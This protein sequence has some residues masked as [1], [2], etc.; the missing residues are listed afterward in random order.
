MLSFQQL[1]DYRALSTS[2]QSRPSLRTYMFTNDFFV[3]PEDVDGDEYQI[4]YYPAMNEPAPMN[5]RGAAAHILNAQGGSKRQAA[6]FYA[7]NCLP[8][9]MSGLE[10]LREPDSET[11]QD[12]A[13]KTIGQQFD[14]F[15]ERHR[16]YKELVISKIMTNGVVYANAAGQ[17]LEDSTGAV[18]TADMGV[19]A[20]HKGNLNG[21]VTALWSVAGT[22]IATQLDN[23]KNQAE[24]EGAEPPTEIYVH[25]LSKI[26]LRANTEFQTWAVENNQIADTIL[27]G[28]MIPDLWGFNW[29]FYGG[30]YKGADGNMKDFIPTTK[31]V[32]CPKPGPWLRAANG[33]TL[34]PSSLEISQ[35]VEQAL[36]NVAKVYGQYAYAKL[37]DNP[38]KLAMFMGDVFG[39]NFADPASI[40]QPTVF[41]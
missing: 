22:K 12:K 6:L 19:S 4:V 27:R 2:Y 24:A 30:K 34:V 31:A 20:N 1:L 21:L 41:G 18:I 3:S 8:F 32:I 7:F 14:Q 26:H 13:R 39:L 35:T 38:L 25:S 15:A 17:I 29:H 37:L 9:P 40:W 23:L 5:T 33:S 10:A 16:I 11:L 28:D 36:S